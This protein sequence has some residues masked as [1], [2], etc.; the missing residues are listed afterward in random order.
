MADIFISYAREDR[1][2]VAELVRL[3]A[4]KN[5]TVWWDRQIFAGAEFDQVID[6]ELNAAGCVIVVWSKYA[7]VS[8]WVRSEA[9]DAMERGA[10]IPIWLDD[11]RIPLPFRSIETIAMVDWPNRARN[12]EI[13]K[14]FHSIAEV[15]SR[16][17]QGPVITATQPESTAEPSLSFR[18]AQRVLDAISPQRA[19]QP[20]APLRIERL[21]ADVA[22]AIA[23]REDPAALIAS[24]LATRLR[25]ALGAMGACIWR[26]SVRV[27]ED[28]ASHAHAEDRA[29]ARGYP[30]Q[31][32]AVHLQHDATQ[33]WTL[34]ISSTT[35]VWRLVVFDGNVEEPGQEE[36]K[37]LLV[38]RELLDLIE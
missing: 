35:G 7:V 34:S 30:D 36:L 2:A 26:G 13:R 33:G 15:L 21:I 10:L 23:R 1:P 32:E 31:R 12:A 22:L 14:L 4:E 19:K 27:H 38:V 29:L 17:N 16:K 37:R 11:A 24:R 20:Q 18:V 8:R 5:W 25:D 9:A 28:W 3:L 6:K